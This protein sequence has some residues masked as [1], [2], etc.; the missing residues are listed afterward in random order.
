M[1]CST[2]AC[3]SVNVLELKAISQQDAVGDGQLSLFSP[4]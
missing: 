2:R 4:C 1:S 3:F